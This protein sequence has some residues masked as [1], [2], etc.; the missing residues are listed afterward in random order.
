MPNNTNTNG[1]AIS[2]LKWGDIVNTSGTTGYS[3]FKTTKIPV[4][5]GFTYQPEIRI[6]RPER[7]ITRDLSVTPGVFTMMVIDLNGDGNLTDEFYAGNFWVNTLNT[8]T[9]PGIASTTTTHYFRNNS[10]LAGGL[11]IPS[12]TT[13][14]EKLMRVIHMFRSPNEF[15]NINLGPTLDG[16]TTSRQ[17]FEIEEYIINVLPF[18]AAN[19]SVERIVA[20]LKPGN[21]PVIVSAV[22]RNFSNTTIANFPVTYRINGGIEIIE[23]VTSSIAAGSTA[24]FTFA[25]KADLSLPA[26]Y[27]IEVYTKLLGDTDATNDSKSTTLSKVGAFATNVT[28]TFDGV[29]DYIVTDVTPALSLTNNY[30]FEAWIN[31]KEPTAF[32]RIID[33]SSILLFVHNKTN[34]ALYK[35]NSLVLSITT[36]T[37]GYV[38]NTALNSI[39]QNKWHHV[40][41]TVSST[42]VYTI[43]I[44]G[45]IASTTQVGTVAAGP[46]TANATNPIFIG[47]NLGLARGFN[48]NIDEVR[49]WSGVRNQATIA[50]NTTTKYIGNEAGLLAYY[51]IAEGNKNFV[52]DATISDNGA[53]ILNADTNGLGN[54]KFWNVP[55]LLQSIQFNNQLSSSYD[56]ITKTYTVLLNDGANVTNAIANFTVGMNSI[57]K[58]NNITQVSGVTPNDYT[59]PVSFVVEGVGFNSGISETY[60]IKMLTGLSNESKL[61]TYNFDT[62]NNPSLAQPINTAIVGSNAT[63]NAAFGIDVSNLK[64]N[65]QVSTGAELFIDDV[66]QENQVTTPLDYSRNRIITVVSENKISRTNYMIVVDAKNTEANFITY[67]VA[68][69]IGTSLINTAEKTIKVFVNNNAN[70]N[71]LLPTF[72]VSA[73]ATTRIGTYLQNNGITTLNYTQPVVY[74]IIAQN[75]NI[76]YWTVTVERAKPTITLLGDAVVSVPKGCVYTEA[77]YTAKDNLDND[78]TSGISV[79]GLIDINTIGQYTLT[80]TATDELNNTSTI[81]RIVNVTN[82]TCNL[83]VNTNSIDGFSIFPNP[84][85]QGKLF[86]ITASNSQKNIEI[87]DVLGK[88]VFSLQ[89]TDK[90]INT[91]NLPSGIYVIKVQQDNKTST[92]KLIV[93]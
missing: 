45:A 43:Y 72:Q 83:A 32:G 41:F 87:Y 77:G 76:V 24:T 61:L 3:D 19:A 48:G 7:P 27:T 6:V 75:G 21:R 54:G 86:I 15:Y 70:L 40:A 28:G 91:V 8:A 62:T 60:T 66:K 51:S 2:Q 5:A 10:S 85:T 71:A 69:Q 30:T 52:Y 29:D 35:E 33:K 38:L 44:D 36:A 18:T 79:T 88:Q 9:S 13:S 80:Y 25:T 12:T 57:A 17:D 58:V 68:N 56:P 93:R 22:I 67:S 89:T 34:L 11:T 47:N 90:E 53:K 50:N 64:A 84:V 37:G 65:F 55:V 16:L 1:F 42:N 20:P 82:D 14:G 31:Q 92:Q 59:N 74:N 81:N 4:Y 63:A 23:T 26:E 39:Q 73:S 46:A 49:I 78:I